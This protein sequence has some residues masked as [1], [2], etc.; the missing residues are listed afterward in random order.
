MDDTSSYVACPYKVLVTHIIKYVWIKVIL[1]VDIIYRCIGIDFGM[2]IKK[3]KNIDVLEN[4]YIFLLFTTTY[5][6]NKS[7]KIDNNNNK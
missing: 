4:T 1:C 6:K 3:W 7:N 5:Q 2:C